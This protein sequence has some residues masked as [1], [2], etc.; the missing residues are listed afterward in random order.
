MF[1]VPVRVHFTFFLLL[2]FLAIRD[3][4]LLGSV[5]AAATNLALYVAVFGCVLLHEFGHVLAARRF[6]VPTRDVTLLP[7]GGL[8]RLERM[9]HKPT[10]ELWV[11]VAGPLVNV[12]LVP[13]F[14][15]LASAT[16]GLPGVA[17]HGSD[18]VA[19][20]GNLFGKLAVINIGLVLF[21]LLPAFPMDGGRVVRALLAMVMPYAR[22]TRIAAGLGIA[23]AALFALAALLGGNPMLFVIAFFVWLG[24]T[25][26]TQQVQ[27]RSAVA[28]MRVRDAMITEFHTL[29]PDQTLGD[30]AR[31][32]LE[33]SQ[34]DF[35]VIDASGFTGLLTRDA[36][37]EGL[38]RSGNTLA[39]AEAVL[40]PIRWVEA[41][42]DLE[43]SFAA[44]DGMTGGT[45][46]VG[47]RGR[48]V[49]LL[50]AENIG[51]FILIRGALARA[52][53]HGA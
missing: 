45:L 26:E 14:L 44:R 52:A 42:A 47:E 40:A 48:L 51:E 41:D 20:P 17:R 50:T 21:N 10:Q 7:F 28:G 13:V 12:V 8:A 25:S 5:A 18:L 3:V 2:A 23:M 32:L 49:G 11:A 37:V 30:A 39:V 1:G 27:T 43:Q 4:F 22:A 31:L 19:D 16:G 35:P 46:L 33:G 9:P 29:R 24:A 15:L 36:L 38:A 53:A 6:G 34:V